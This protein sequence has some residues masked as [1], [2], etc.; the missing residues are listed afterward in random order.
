MLYYP[1]NTYIKTTGVAR[2]VD[3]FP[4]YTSTYTFCTCTGHTS[5]KCSTPTANTS[6]GIIATVAITIVNIVILL[7]TISILVILVTVLIVKRK[8]QSLAVN[9]TEESVQIYD[10]VDDNNALKKPSSDTKLYEELDISKMEDRS[11][12]ATMK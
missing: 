8:K 2:M 4:G 3:P 1:Y 9:Y 12:Y 6:P 5:V 11:Q 7:L 10:E